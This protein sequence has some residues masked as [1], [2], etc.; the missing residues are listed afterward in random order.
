M[1]ITEKA[2]EGDVS[3]TNSDGLTSPRKS[4]ITPQANP[5]SATGSRS[6]GTEAVRI[7]WS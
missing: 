5:Q 3:E 4:V 1:S 7:F 2:D 6:T